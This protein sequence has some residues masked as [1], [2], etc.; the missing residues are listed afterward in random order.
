VWHV[1]DVLPPYPILEGAIVQPAYPTRLSTVA[2]AAPEHQTPGSVERLARAERL[3]DYF[4]LQLRLA[5]AVAAAADLPLADTVTRYTNFYRRFGLGR[6]QNGP[7]SPAWSTY[8]ERLSTLE[9]HEQRVV[10][11]QTFFVQSPPESL[12]PGQ[13]Q[14]GCFGC[15]PLDA[16]GRVRIHFLNMDHHG[17][18]PL[19]R[20]K[21]EA[22][23]QEL[24]AMFTYV[25]KTY[26]DAKEVLGG[27]WLYNLEAYRRL[28][29]PI[30]GDSRQIQEGDATFQGTSRWG[31]FLDHQEGVK[32]ALREQFLENLKTLDVHRLWEVFPLPTY[33]VH[34]SIKAFY[35]WYH[36][37]VASA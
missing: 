25:N 23:R 21:I 13:R 33:S 31:Q 30:Y 20:A 11:T 9:T 35:D 6:L 7:V 5:E 3:R 15:D 10:W 26:A 19:S 12:P 24:H 18:G 37:D 14:F 16:D 27:S 34:A 1:T 22:R 17:G 28:F 29:P 32:P 8:T 2:G 4:D 36:V